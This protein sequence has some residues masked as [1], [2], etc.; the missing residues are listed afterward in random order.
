MLLLA[1]E[2]YRYAFRTII[3]SLAAF[4]GC[5]A[6]SMPFVV[7]MFNQ[8]LLHHLQCQISAV[9]S[10]V[11]CKCENFLAH[12]TTLRKDIEGKTAHTQ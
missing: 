7:R 1:F 6:V 8:F 12:I 5:S 11:N 10:V 4:I 3:Y 2:R 9:C